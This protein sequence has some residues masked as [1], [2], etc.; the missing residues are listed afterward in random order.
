MGRVNNKTASSTRC[1]EKTPEFPLRAWVYWRA[2]LACLVC[3]LLLG[4]H[5]Q[6][7]HA[8]HHGEVSDLQLERGADGL[9]L[10]AAL[11][12]EL[13][14]IVQNALY[15]G[16]SMYFLAD[17]EV[18][19]P[20]WY[21]TDK[22]VVRATRYLRLSYQPLT[23]RWRLAQSAAPFA[24]T[25]LGVSLEQSFD[26]LP[27]ALAALQRI[28]RWKIADEGSLDDDLAYL[29]NFQFRLDLSQLPRPLQI[30]AVGGSSW[31]IAVTRS[32]SLPAVEGQR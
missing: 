30:G 18:L 13:P 25:G 7:A 15:K 17:A 2:A 5:A 24:A 20:R 28:A 4:L 16:I 21:W 9:Y 26:D 22:V 23:R 1:C 27:E 10:T 14:A 11:Q 31:N 12:L 29:V 3:A 32:A 6:P 8:Q 19:R